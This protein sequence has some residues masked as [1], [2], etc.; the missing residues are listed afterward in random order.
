MSDKK[1]TLTEAAEKFNQS[2]PGT[3]M[4]VRDSSEMA[5]YMDSA[6]FAQAQRAAKLLS[7][8]G[9]MVPAHFRGKPGAVFVVLELAQR[10]KLSPILLLQ[11]IYLVHGTPGLSSQLVRAMLHGSGLFDAL[12][13]RFEGEGMARTCTCFAKRKDDG[14]LKE[15]ICSMKMANDEGWINKNGSKWKTMPDRMLK[16]RS[17]AFFARD[18]CPEVLLGLSTAD[19]LS[20][21]ST[22]DVKFVETKSANDD[23]P[24]FPQP[25][26]EKKIIVQ[27]KTK[28]KKEKKPKAK[29]EPKDQDTNSKDYYEKKAQ[30]YDSK[31]RE[32][33]DDDPWDEQDPR[34]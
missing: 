26:P 24:D 22:I 32:P 31:A 7:E 16:Y 9:E 5:M 13:W 12:S 19:E 15:S 8:A 29:K 25:E 28:P 18:H 17:S 6:L 21:N 3:G 11:N 33:G 20:D 23:I 1:E 4:T 30:E 34:D 2:K 10:V 14:S 27:D